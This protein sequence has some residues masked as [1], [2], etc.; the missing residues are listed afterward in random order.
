MSEDFLSVFLGNQVRAK[1]SRAFAF[2]ES[3]AF[4]LGGVAKRSGVSTQA[5]AREIKALEKIGIIKK[6]KDTGNKQKKTRLGARIRNVSPGTKR[7]NAWILNAEFKHLRALSSFIHEVSPVRYENIVAALKSSGRLSTVIVSGCFM[8]DATRPV[9]IIVVI[10][11]VNES[12][13]LHAIKSLETTFGRE[14][15]YASFSTPEFRYRL[16]IQDHL[17]RDT[18][19]YPHHVLLDRAHLL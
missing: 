5:A 1:L 18:I 6:V 2:N 8:G 9:D 12:R 19:D 4:T 10:D 16:T 11:N 14:I 13:L 7:E 3:E 17:I 15:R